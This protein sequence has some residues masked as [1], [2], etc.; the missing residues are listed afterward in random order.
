ML[1]KQRKNCHNVRVSLSSG[2]VPI[3]GRVIKRGEAMTDISL[4]ITASVGGKAKSAFRLFAHGRLGNFPWLD[5]VPSDL[6]VWACKPVGRRGDCTTKRSTGD[7]WRWKGR[8]R[9]AR[10]R[11]PFFPSHSRWREW[12]IIA[13]GDRRLLLAELRLRSDLRPQRHVGF[14]VAISLGP[15]RPRRGARHLGYLPVLSYLPLFYLHGQG[16]SRV[17]CCSLVAASRKL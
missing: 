9:D 10:Y 15:R 17:G 12:R 13:V 7:G 2:E 14:R 1:Y 11:A 3:A 5:V 6:Y 16:E 4:Q 8:G